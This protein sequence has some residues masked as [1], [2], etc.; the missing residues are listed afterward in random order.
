MARSHCAIFGTV[1]SMAKYE[2]LSPD[3]AMTHAAVIG[4]LLRGTVLEGKDYP[5][6]LDDA[7]DAVGDNAA[8][9]VTRHP[10]GQQYC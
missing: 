10:V 2:H 6:A 5:Q 3:K 1:G 9:E 8:A 4:H 7:Y